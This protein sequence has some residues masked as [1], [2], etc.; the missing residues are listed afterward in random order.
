MELINEV[1]RQRDAV[2]ASHRCGSRSATAG[3]LMFPFAPIS[4]AEVEG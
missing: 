1:Y 3:S 2:P 4:G